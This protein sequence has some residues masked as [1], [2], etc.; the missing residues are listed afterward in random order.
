MVRVCTKAT[1][2]VRYQVGDEVKIHRPAH[3]VASARNGLIL[4]GCAASLFNVL[5][6][7][8]LAALLLCFS[9]CFPDQVEAPNPDAPDPT[10]QIATGTIAGEVRTSDD[11]PVPNAVVYLPDIDLSTTT[12]AQGRFILDNLSEGTYD[13][14]AVPPG[15]ERAQA[16]DGVFPTTGS[17]VGVSIGDTARI[18]LKLPNE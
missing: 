10:T 7:R 4:C 13:I 11:R 5:L 6:M 14:E 9:G 8:L 2:L 15:T 3:S 17:T 16:V 1:P 12:D 18:V